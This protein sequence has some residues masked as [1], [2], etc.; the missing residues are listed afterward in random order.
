MGRILL[1]SGTH[2]RPNSLVRAFNS[3]ATIVRYR[4]DPPFNDISFSSIYSPLKPYDKLQRNY[5]KHFRF[6]QIEPEKFLSHGG[7]GAVWAAKYRSHDND[8]NQEEIAVKI[9]YNYYQEGSEDD[10]ITATDNLDFLHKQ[11]AREVDLRPPGP[12]P[13]IVPILDDF[14]DRAPPVKTE[15][16]GGREASWEGVEKFPDGFGGRPYTLYLL[17]ERF[18]GSL[19]DLLNGKWKPTTTFSSS[20]NSASFLMRQPASHEIASGSPFEIPTSNMEFS[21]LCL[22]TEEA[23]GVAVQMVEAVAHLQRYHIA[24]RDIKPSNFLVRSRNLPKRVDLLNGETVEAINLRLQVA[25]TDFGC[26]I[27]TVDHA[28]GRDCTTVSHSGNIALWAPEVA[29][30]FSD[31]Q[32]SDQQCT[33]PSI[34]SRADLW[35]VATIAYQLFGRPNPFLSGEL[36]STNYAESELP[37]L[38]SAA[39]GVLV[40]VLHSCLRRNP[41]ARP[42]APLV[43]DV[44]HTW[45]LLANL[46]RFLSPR[47][48][49]KVV[50][51]IPLPMEILVKAA[52]GDFLNNEE[53]WLTMKLA[54]E[55]FSRLHKRLDDP[56]RRKLRQLLQ[57]TWTAD[58][59]LGAAKVTGLRHLF[60][61]RVTLERFA[62]CLAFV[63]F[64]EKAKLLSAF[65]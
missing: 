60:Y 42:P 30:H 58:W 63:Q 23:I 2:P 57:L 32:T 50:P 31:P 10:D 35:A 8:A 16:E 41:S 11:R 36:S 7:F 28:I 45:C 3:V 26:A 38:P 51:Q 52:G 22:R 43:A 6:E 20:M 33:L 37:M 47:L 65:K 21:S 25:L 62:F 17:M 49:D 15:G 40:W 56:L 18:D 34:Y 14:F 44:L 39:P 1:A 29:V 64:A 13:N 54:A 12:H 46:K 19:D 48:F 24:H 27:R 53:T 5:V 9:H 61:Q 59:L 55:G 4:N